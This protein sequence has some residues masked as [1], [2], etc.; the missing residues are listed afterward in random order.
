LTEIENDFEG[1]R[2]QR[3]SFFERALRG[4]VLP[5]GSEKRAEREMQLH[6]LCVLSGKSV[7]DFQRGS[8]VVGEQISPHQVDLRRRGRRRNPLK[9]RNSRGWLIGAKK[10][11]S[12]VVVCVG[13]ARRGAQDFAKLFFSKV[14]FSLSNIKIAEIVA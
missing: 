13:I 3:I 9:I 14:E 5:F 1:L 4:A 7:R 10:Y 2:L 8:G 11:H 6:I 12:E